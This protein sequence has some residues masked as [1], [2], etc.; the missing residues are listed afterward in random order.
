MILDWGSWK[1]DDGRHVSNVWGFTGVCA[2]SRSVLVV[3]KQLAW[4]YK[5]SRL[6][7][8]LQA[9]WSQAAQ[10]DLNQLY[11]DT[12]IEVY[13][14]ENYCRKKRK[15]RK[16]H[17]TWSLTGCYTI[18]LIFLFELCTRPPVVSLSSYLTTHTCEVLS[19]QLALFGMKGVF[20]IPKVILKLTS[21]DFKINII[22]DNS[23]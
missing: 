6:F 18:E 8:S 20:L 23:A 9:G 5:I 17:K 21:F 19:L 15:Q 22:R 12:H 7:D 1:C 11:V 3:Y 14:W 2:G 13:R 10:N 16:E 4:K